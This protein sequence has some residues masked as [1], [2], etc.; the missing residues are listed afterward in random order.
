MD[1]ERAEAFAQAGIETTNSISEANVLVE[2]SLGN[3]RGGDCRV[4]NIRANIRQHGRLIST[5]K[6]R[7]PTRCDPSMIYEVAREVHAMF[8]LSATEGMPS[9]DIETLALA[10]RYYAARSPAALPPTGQSGRLS[11][12][13]SFRAEGFTP[14]FSKMKDDLDVPAFLRKQMD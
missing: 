5:F 10:E 6:A 3:S 12:K 13:L 1:A 11:T 9:P 14:N 7:G 8:G 2:V 4:R